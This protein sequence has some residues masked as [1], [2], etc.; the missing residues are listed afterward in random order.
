MSSHEATVPRLLEAT[1]GQP[2]PQP[3]VSQAESVGPSTSGEEEEEIDEGL[4]N[5]G[6]FNIEASIAFKYLDG[7]KSKEQIPLHRV[8]EL[9]R[10]HHALYQ[11]I[12]TAFE[13]EKAM[14]KK[15]KMLQAEV[16]KQKLEMDKTGAKVFDDNAEIGEL[17]RELLRCQNEVVLAH[18]REAKLSK[19]IEEALIAKEGLLDD[20]EEIRKHK[21]DMLEP[22]LVANTKE[23]K[24]DL[25][26]RRHQAE[27]LEKDLEEKEQI[28]ESITKDKEELFAER[29]KQEV[30]L[31]K[32]NEMP[33]KIMK[34]AEVLR[35]GIASLVIENVKQ[36]QLSTQLDRDMEKLARK[37]RDLEDEK[38]GQAAEFDR[39]KEE[40]MDQERACDDIFHEHEMA[41]EMLALQEG[42]RVRIETTMRQTEARIRSTHEV[43]LRYNREK[44]QLVKAFRKLEGVVNSVVATVPAVRQHNNDVH[45]N[46]EA[47]ERECKHY[48][49]AVRTLRKEI[50]ILMHAFIEGERHA[51]GEKELLVSRMEA[52]REIEATISRLNKELEAVERSTVQAKYER[53]MK[54]REMLRMEAKVRKGKDDAQQREMEVIDAAKKSQESQF[55]L[56]EFAALYDKVK[57][58]RNRYVNMIASTQQRA[59]EMKEKSRILRSEVEILRNEIALKDRELAKKRQDNNTAYS[60]R[61]HAKMEAN[62]YLMQYRDRRSLIDQQSGRIDTLTGS[63]NSC[64]S[65][66]TSI[67]NRYEQVSHERNS[68]GLQ[69]L[70][71]NDEL[72]MLH[73]RHNVLSR[74]L[75]QGEHALQELEDD[76]RTYNRYC[77]E[78]ERTIRVFQ[79][80]LPKVNQLKADHDSVKAQVHEAKNMFSSETET[81]SEDRVRHL[82]GIDLSQLQLNAQVQRLE[83]RLAQQEE[84]LLEKDLILEEITHLTDRLRAQAQQGREE[85]AQV[86]SQLN[87]RTRKLSNLS[88]SMMALVAELSIA[89]TLAT[90]LAS[91]VSAKSSLAEQLKVIF[92]DNDHLTALPAPHTFIPELDREWCE[93]KSR[94][95][96]RR[97]TR[98]GDKRNGSNQLADGAGEWTLVSSA[99]RRIFRLGDGSITTAEPRPNAYVPAAES[100]PVPRPYGAFPPFKPLESSG[101]DLGGNLKYYKKPVEKPI[102]L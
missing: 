6:L 74:V 93:I 7:L 48:Q 52:N 72:C 91:E 100:V 95:L 33:G 75:C 49:E 84:R 78:L 54:A 35:D 30:A 57:S 22:Q 41:K 76:I 58:E 98:A 21:T 4:L 13:Y 92:Q 34:Q 68:A 62:R 55:R 24:L 2:E 101:V 1:S 88:K 40:M 25:M 63:L 83:A 97:K 79:K 89:R 59:M 15:S 69:Y 29:E 28:L 53:E 86:M 23:I 85:S 31:A 47:T 32:A 20:I 70:E 94:E 66:L 64:A 80:R 45:L 61:D 18:E 51:A 90:A 81:P 12:L 77:Q 37:R 102:V 65:E 10:K 73:E 60:Q 16:T 17:K 38:V 99:A 5:S 71:R 42:E 46:L 43:L 87:E 26:Q 8:E 39:K 9:K 44:D 36:G 11:H 50:D 19:D 96:T 56:T 82:D 27:N 14:I 3:L 67:K